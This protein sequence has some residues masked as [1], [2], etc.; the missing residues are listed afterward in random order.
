MSLEQESIVQSWSS[1]SNFIFVFPSFR[2]LLISVNHNTT[3]QYDFVCLEEKHFPGAVIVLH[4]E[5]EGDHVQ[6]S[7]M[8]G[9]VVFATFHCLKACTFS[10]CNFFWKV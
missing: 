5:R 6:S 10:I 8:M 3:C 1:V 7:G 9:M 2:Y 4:M